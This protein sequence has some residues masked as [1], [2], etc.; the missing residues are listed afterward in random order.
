LLCRW[1]ASRG[2]EF[3]NDRD[4]AVNDHAKLGFVLKKLSKSLVTRNCSPSALKSG[5]Q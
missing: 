1:A 2:L 5:F 4:I 3:S